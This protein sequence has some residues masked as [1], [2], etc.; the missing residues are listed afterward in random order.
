MRL[1]HRSSS[2]PGPCNLQVFIS[3]AWSGRMLLQGGCVVPVLVGTVKDNSIIMN[4]GG[5]CAALMTV[6]QICLGVMLYCWA[7][8]AAV[9][10]PLSR[11]T[12]RL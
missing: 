2:A 12:C 6:R 11:S 4:C 5:E 1:Q 3:T 9:K 8:L 10:W 7:D